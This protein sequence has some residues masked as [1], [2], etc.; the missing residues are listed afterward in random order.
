MAYIDTF[1]AFV[2]ETTH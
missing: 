2:A 1:V